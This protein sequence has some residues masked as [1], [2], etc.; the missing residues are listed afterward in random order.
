MEIKWHGD[1]FFSLYNP[2][3]YR[4]AFWILP[5]GYEKE[6][7][8]EDFDG[9]TERGQ[10]LKVGGARSLTAGNRSPAAACCRDRRRWSRTAGSTRWL[11]GAESSHRST[12]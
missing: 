3:M 10:E 11:A 2:I 8:H 7:M 9:P 6:P 4:A 1:F 5:R 12:C